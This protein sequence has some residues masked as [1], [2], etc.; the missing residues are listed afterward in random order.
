MIIDVTKYQ[1]QMMN[2]TKTKKK[3]THQ[4]NESTNWC[5]KYNPIIIENLVSKIQSNYNR[6]LLKKK[7]S[8]I[9][10]F[11]SGKKKMTEKPGDNKKMSARVK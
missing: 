5:P 9:I 4:K 3:N 10:T 8:S 2:Q 6:E 11:K 1:N 7:L